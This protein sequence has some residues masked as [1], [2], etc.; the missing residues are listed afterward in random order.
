[1]IIFYVSLIVF[2]SMNAANTWVFYFA[3]FTLNFWV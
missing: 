2:S 1:M 3:F